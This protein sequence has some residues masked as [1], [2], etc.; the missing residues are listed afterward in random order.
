MSPTRT[1]Q[2]GASGQ[3]QL[4]QLHFPGDRQV[5]QVHAALDHQ[6]PE[7]VQRRRD[8]EAALRG[9]DAEA[10]QQP[11]PLEDVQERRQV[12]DSALQRYDVMRVAE[13]RVQGLRAAV[14]LEAGH[15]GRAGGRGGG[16]V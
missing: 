6:L 3:L 16:G 11:Q 13:L 10:G 8:G 1:P 9:G 12:H 4:L 5:R 7:G 14:G 2:H 15:C